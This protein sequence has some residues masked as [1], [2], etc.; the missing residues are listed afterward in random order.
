VWFVGFEDVGQ[1]GRLLHM[2]IIAQ[3]KEM[4]VS[5]CVVGL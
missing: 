4:G 2:G 5:S 3:K 1:R